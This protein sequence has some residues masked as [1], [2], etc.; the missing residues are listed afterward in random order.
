MFVKICLMFLEVDMC[1]SGTVTGPTVTILSGGVPASP[2][3]CYCDVTVDSPT[4]INFNYDGPDF[5]N[6]Y[7]SLQFS[8]IVLGCS[9]G[10]LKHHLKSSSRLTLL[11]EIIYQLDWC[12]FIQDQSGTCYRQRVLKTI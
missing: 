1:T 7:M 4:D 2:V 11:K 6:C 5:S 8:D 9:D 10:V 12:L 3:T